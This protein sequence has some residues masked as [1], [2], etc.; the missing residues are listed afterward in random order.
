MRKRT[1]INQESIDMLENILSKEVTSLNKDEIM[2]LRARRDYLT[3]AEIEEYD[4]VLTI[5]KVGKKPKK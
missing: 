1:D 3:S 4:S 5:I 2:F